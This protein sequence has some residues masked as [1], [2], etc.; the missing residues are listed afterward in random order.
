[1]TARLPGTSQLHPWVTFC[2]T[3]LCASPRHM[4]LVHGPVGSIVRAPLDFGSSADLA[5]Q[6]LLPLTNYGMNEHTAL[7]V[8]WSL[9]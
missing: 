3:H 8:L 2:P 6:A 9:P 5:L 1:M 4:R 7:V